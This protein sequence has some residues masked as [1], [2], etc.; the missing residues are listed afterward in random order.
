[1]LKSINKLTKFVLF[2]MVM[3]ILFCIPFKLMAQ[4]DTISELEEKLSDISDE[5]KIILESLFVQAQK[6]EELKR[7]RDE[8]TQE[9]NNMKEE[10][11]NLESLIEKETENYDEK[12][13][14]LKQILVSYQRMGPG[15]YIEIILDADS[16][17]NFLERVNVVRDLTRNTGELLESIDEI[18]N[19][20][21]S[22]KENLDEKLVALNK[23]EEDLVKTIDNEQQEADKLEERLAS[24]HDDREYYEER[25]N[26][27]MAMMKELDVFM[28]DAVGEFSSITEKA[29]LSED[30]IEYKISSKGIVGV[31][32]QVTF[33]R[34]V[35]ENTNLSEIVFEFY[36][37]KV[38]M[39]FPEKSL[40][41]IGNF[42]AVDKHTIEFQVEEGSLYNMLL[43][44]ETV[45]GFFE[46][47]NFKLNL[48]PLLGNSTIKNVKSFEGY[49]EVT[50]DVNLK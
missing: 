13:S 24:L 35:N 47:G 38:K 1:M 36:P 22:E 37:D 3:A 32:S 40:Y 9:I 42:V 23:K 14:I 11:A 18:R 4:E 39:N 33:N 28:K 41:L 10:I 26:S 7:E 5:E 6:I 44:K 43:T 45:E 17:T 20:L 19:R 25:L 8:L 50:V 34:I 2:L 48:K 30:S 16:I 31:I 27:I 49:V 21:I 29:N 15:S 46:D 12:L